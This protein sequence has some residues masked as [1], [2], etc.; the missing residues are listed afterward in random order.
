M[1]SRRALAATR[2]A[3]RSFA[4]GKIDLRRLA[5]LAKPRKRARNS[6]AKPHGAVN[7]Q[8]RCHVICLVVAVS[9]L[10]RIS[11]IATAAR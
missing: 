2:A 10:R 6:F 4:R 9:A 7:A 8:L 5:L 11:F 1:A 3:E